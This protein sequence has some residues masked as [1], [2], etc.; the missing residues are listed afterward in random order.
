MPDMSVYKQIRDYI[1]ADLDPAN[2]N[3]VIKN[4]VEFMILIECRDSNPNTEK[5]D[6]NAPRTD[7]ETGH[8]LISDVCIKRKIRNVVDMLLEGKIGYK[9]SVKKGVTLESNMKQAIRALGVDPDDAKAVQAARKNDPDFDRK[10]LAYMCENFYDI[11]LFGEVMTTFTKHNMSCGQVK[12]AVQIGIG[13]SVDPICP[14]EMTLTRSTV[15]TEDE[16]ETKQNMFG[17]KHI[18]PYGLYCVRGSI[19]AYQA[20]K[21]TGLTELDKELL[22][23]AILNMYNLD[24]SAGR[25]QM[26]V[27]KLFIWTHDSMFGIGVPSYKLYE[28]VKITRK[29]D[30]P[31]ARCF[32]DYKIDIDYDAIPKSV[33][34]EIREP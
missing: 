27:R 23:L 26:A 15:S 32:E 21:V 8:G 20:S 25:S 17:H 12:G 22:W 3:N 1:K 4:R 31:V 34:L 16:A 13:R 6:D 9:D 33:T 10:A 28:S 14:Q 30:V 29:D 2:L 7:Y 11:R 19:N 5:E 24:Q 18:V